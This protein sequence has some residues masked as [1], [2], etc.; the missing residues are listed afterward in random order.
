MTTS[1]AKFDHQIALFVL[2]DRAIIR[3]HPVRIQSVRVF[4]TT[5]GYSVT[6]VSQLFHVKIVALDKSD[7]RESCPEFD[8]ES[9]GFCF[10]ELNPNIFGT[11]SGAKF[12]VQI[13][14]SLECIAACLRARV[15]Y[16]MMHHSSSIFP[17]ARKRRRGGSRRVLGRRPIWFGT[18]SG[19]S[20]VAASRLPHR[21]FW[22]RE[23]R[24]F[25]LARIFTPRGPRR[26][27]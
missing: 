5:G 10:Q 16:H 26:R 1:S 7:W 27:F 12:G 25:V 3:T 9:T 8:A 11:K 18:Y 23:A 22:A 19:S 20:D 2:P 17:R 15:R 6:P 4:S 13:T 21:C 14:K 24:R